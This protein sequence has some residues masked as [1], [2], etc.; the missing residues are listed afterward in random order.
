MLRL[1]GGRPVAQNVSDKIGNGPTLGLGDAL[2][3]F[4]DLGVH[5]AG[6]EGSRRPTTPS[7]RSAGRE[8]TDEEQHAITI[9]TALALLGEHSAAF[10]QTSDVSS[11]NDVMPGCHDTLR[12]GG[13]Q[14]LLLMGICI[15]AVRTMLHFG[16]ALGSCAPA[17]A[18]VSRTIRVVVYYIDRQPS[19]M[20]ERFQTLALEAQQE[21]WPCR[22]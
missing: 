9:A 15:G 19:R 22:R 12:N 20:D 13:D 3:E 8:S 7:N 2:D 4:G 18:S 6:H 14:D 16:S 1:P 5:V 17:A 21:E 10:S 11:A